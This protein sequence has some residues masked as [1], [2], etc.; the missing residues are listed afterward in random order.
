MTGR[1]WRVAF[2]LL[3]LAGSAS[4]QGESGGPAPTA[5]EADYAAVVETAVTKYILP[6]YQDLAAGTGNLVA[7]T[8]KFCAAPDVATRNA[9]AAAFATTVQAWAGVD[10]LRFGSMAWGGRYER[11]AFFPDVH[12]TGARQ[13]RRFLAEEEESLLQPGALA[14]QS[15]AVQ[16]LPALESLLYAGS[17]ALLTVDEPES[18]RCALTLAIAENMNEIASGALAGWQGAD[19]WA[20][21]I[22]APGAQN[23]VYRTHAEAMT[24]ILKALLTG[25]EQVRDHRLLPAVGETPEDAKASR[26]PYN[27]SGQALAYLAASAAALERFANVSGILSLAPESAKWIASSVAFEF[28][29]LKRAL[30]AVGSDLAAALADPDRRAKLTYATIV[31]ASLR[32]LFQNRLAPAAGITS[33]FNSLDGD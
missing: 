21:L 26:T 6:G 31:L 30:D 22:R 17:K 27:L 20:S 2:A 19:G 12:G 3:L 25:L 24:E 8:E 15:A 10:F 5:T 18:F 9:L 28:A 7:S 32:D 13:L 14:G 11:F 4:A 23:P 16:G 33:G 29:N 1:C